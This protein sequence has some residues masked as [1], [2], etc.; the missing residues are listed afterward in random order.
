MVIIYPKTNE[1]GD[2]H[3]CPKQESTGVLMSYFF[4]CPMD[5]YVGESQ[6]NPTQCPA[7][8]SSSIFLTNEN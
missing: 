4:T 5:E 6:L 2:V 8:G 3:L 7:E 1:Y